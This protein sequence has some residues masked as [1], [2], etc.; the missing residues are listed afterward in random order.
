LKGKGIERRQCK[1]NKGGG[2]IRENYRRKGKNKEKREERRTHKR[3]MS[4]KRS[5]E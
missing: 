5:R 3:E 2:I 1:I 4:D